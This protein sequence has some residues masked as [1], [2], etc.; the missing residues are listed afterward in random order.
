MADLNKFYIGGEWVAPAAPRTVPVVNP[1]TEETL[2]EVALGTAADVDAAVAAARAAWPA[3]AET[4]R[5]ERLALFTRIMEI[6][7]K[8][9]REIGAAV[10][11]EMGA[12]LT[13]AERAQAGAGLGHFISTQ[14]VLK[15]YPFEERIGS[16]MVVREPIGVAGQITPWNWPMN[17]IACKV[18]PALAAGC[19]MVLKPS[20]YTPRSALLVAEILHE[21][22]VP[23]GVFNLVNGDGPDVGAALS[24]HPDL[25]MISF[26]GSTRAG[27]DVAI[28]AAP[29]VKRVTQELG[30]KSANIILEDANFEKAIAGGA[31]H[32]FGNSGQ[33]CNAPTRML[34]PA[35]RMDEA[36]SIAACVADGLRVG[37]PR[38]KETD[39]G[40]VVNRTQWEKIQR[41]IDSGVAEGA[42]LA[43]GGPGRPQG[44]N[45]G[46]YVRPTVFANVTPEMTIAREEIFGPVLS[47]IAYKDEDDAVRI[48][49]DTPYGLA[50]YVSSGDIERARR[51]A[52]RIRAGNVNLN[53]AMNERRAPFGGMKQSGNG[54]EW[55]RFGLEE[56]LEV[57]A[58]S[59]C[60]E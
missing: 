12:P 21:A 60:G 5:E 43:A 10:S 47:I 39:L 9:L 25:D 58:I 4:S 31:R 59:G 23:P 37:D 45:K 32:C 30:G 50:G 56:Y 49:N 33:S 28:R 42:T 19:T 38:A 8:R 54:R 55:G 57:K 36:A 13:F 6:F 51:V 44:L 11:D 41:L 35:A 18:A 40:P 2:Y 46:F 1:A 22:G 17:Q 15:T 34:V 52:R 48:A 27:I 53:S 7:A 16:A 20:E 24:A 3:Y 14:E 29:T 26:T